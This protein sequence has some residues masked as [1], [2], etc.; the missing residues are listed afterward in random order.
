MIN[1]LLFILFLNVEEPSNG[2][3]CCKA[4]PPQETMWEIFGH[5]KDIDV[6]KS[7]G[8]KF[9]NKM[10]KTNDCKIDWCRHDESKTNKK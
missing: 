1:L 10:F 9:C 4:S 6:A 5:D 8:L 3:W 7:L 2:E